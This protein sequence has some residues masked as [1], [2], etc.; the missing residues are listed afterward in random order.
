MEAQLRDPSFFIHEFSIAFSCSILSGSNSVF[1]KKQILFI[2]IIMECLTYLSLL[3][4]AV[5]S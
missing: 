1:D 2:Q 4:I 5:Q 3:N